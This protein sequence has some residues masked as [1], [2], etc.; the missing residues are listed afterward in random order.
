MV[1]AIRG[2][3]KTNN[4]RQKTNNNQQSQQTG[5]GTSIPGSVPVLVLIHTS[6]GVVPKTDSHNIATPGSGS[7]TTAI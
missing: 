6:T 4:P 2:Q 5:T 3:G 1:T 7:K